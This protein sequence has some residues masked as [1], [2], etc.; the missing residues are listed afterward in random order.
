VAVR[1]ATCLAVAFIVASL[2]ILAL[3]V[4]T[5]GAANRDVMNNYLEQ[6]LGGWSPDQD[7]EVLVRF[8]SA[9]TLYDIGHLEN[10]GLEA[11]HTFHVLPTV[12]AVGRP[13]AVWRMSLDPR[14][15]WI[16]Y[17]RP[18][19]YMMEN[20][21][22]S[23]KATEVWNSIVEDQSVQYPAIDGSGVTVVVVD[24]GID[25]GHPDLDYK[26]KV[27]MNLKS[28]SNLVWT[29]VE[30]SDT[31]SG[32]GTHVAGTVAG[33]GDGSAG[34]RR[35]VAPGARLI[36]LSTGEATAIIN[37]LGALEW[38]YDNSRPGSNPYNIRCATNSWGTAGAPYDPNDS[39]TLVTEALT[40]DNNVVVTFAAGNA[41]SND[42]DGSTISTNPYSNTPAAI[43]VAAYTRDGTGVTTFSSRGLAT[44][45]ATWPDIGAPGLGINSTRARLTLITLEV[46]LSAVQSGNL[47]N[48]DPLY[49]A[50]S[51][52]SMATPHVAGE[53]ALLFQAAP[54]LRV[55]EVH[56]DYG[57]T[58][59][60]S[61]ED[62]ANWFSNPRTRI[63]ETELIL[64]LSAHML[65]GNGTN[66]KNDS[67]LVP[68]Y[69]GWTGMLSLP[70]DFAQGYGFTDMRAAVSLALTVQK[71]RSVNPN[72]TV[73][74]A[75]SQ[76]KDLKDA[77]TPVAYEPE[78]SAKTDTLVTGWTGEYTRYNDQ[79]GKAL[80]VQ[81]STKYVYVPNGTTSVDLDLTYTTLNADEL[82]FGT[83]SWTVEFPDGTTQAASL[84]GGS[85]HKTATISAEGKDGGVWKVSVVGAGFRIQDRL[86]PYQYTEVRLPYAFGLRAHIATSADAP[87]V[88]EFHDYHAQ[89][90]QWRFFEDQNSNQ[91]ANGTIV[92][93]RPVFDLS[94][95]QVFPG[96]RAPP[97]GGSIGG[98]WLFW[99][100]AVIVLG[101]G[102]WLYNEQRV[103]A[104]RPALRVMVEARKVVDKAKL[105]PVWDGGK[106]AVGRVIAPLRRGGL[107]AALKRQAGNI[108]GIRAKLHFKRAS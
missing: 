6:V 4:G 107:G 97:A 30:N 18:L 74:Q 64:K 39:I 32:H 35:G 29:E 72:T 103:C 84:F 85:G 61:A 83:V 31:S 95:V 88:V 73:L 86:P 60:T 1:G 75:Y 105:G 22:T 89:F 16:E 93:M 34:A 58:N 9:P 47:Y 66:S 71:M 17:N 53:V 15:A 102:L 67:N 99:L 37:A 96:A 50:I 40:Y 78:V 65:P 46:C 79:N 98:S 101:A 5:A 55:S 87:T 38:V 94:R 14:V 36:G 48:C 52:T 76:W 33:N 77:G 45:N 13:D 11:R 51:G 8:A 41:G 10:A 63:H 70:R 3:V 80:L 81:N 24:S 43:S 54:S 57:S 62:I 68:V 104:G 19:T 91:T 56:A 20:S 106:R 2:P 42:Q 27:I 26:N 49:M 69:D 100:L 82:S 12:W 108:K 44:D 25:A 90:A 28:D 7:I 92:M 21:T 59:N 23:I